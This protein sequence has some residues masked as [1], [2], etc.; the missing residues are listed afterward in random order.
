MITLLS[1]FRAF[2][3]HLKPHS[4]VGSFGKVCKTYHTIVRNNNLSINISNDTLVGITSHDLFIDV[5]ENS[6]RRGHDFEIVEV[7][8]STP[9]N[10][11]YL[12]AP[13]HL[14]TEKIQT[15]QISINNQILEGSYL[16]SNEQ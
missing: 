13:T 11:A 9:N 10:Y 16:M 8:K 3:L 2:I 7:Q 15:L 5:L 1:G 4:S 14:Q 12:V 6:F